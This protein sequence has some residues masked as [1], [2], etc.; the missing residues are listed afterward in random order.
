MPQMLCAM[1]PA[2]DSPRHLV[3]AGDPAAADFHALAA[4]AHE[5]LGPRRALLAVDAA[6]AREWFRPRA[7]W[8]AEM[9]ALEGRATAYLCEDYTC[10][11]PVTDPAAL[12]ALLWPDQA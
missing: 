4:V 1:E 12:R 9:R 10:R 7:P 6:D 8:L 11:S 3:I 5:R 2:L